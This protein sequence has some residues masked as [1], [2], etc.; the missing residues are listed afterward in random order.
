MP[1]L[2]KQPAAA[3]NDVAVELEKKPV[4]TVLTQLAVKRDQGLSSSEATQRLAKYGPNALAEKE[5][6]LWRKILG[7]FTGP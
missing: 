2:T 4:D 7:P 5:V 1:A 6:S 3:P